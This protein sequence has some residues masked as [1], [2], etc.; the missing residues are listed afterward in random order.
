MTEEEVEELVLRDLLIYRNSQGGVTLSGGEPLTQP[1][2]AAAILARCTQAGVHTALDTSGVGEWERLAM[3]LPVTDLV[4]L[5][6][7]HVDTEKHRRATGVDCAGI[8]ANAARLLQT[9]ANLLVRVPVVPGFNDRREDMAAI[10]D[11]LHALVKTSARSTGGG[12]AHLA[13]ELLPFHKLAADKYKAL[14]MR[15]RAAHLSPPTKEEI[16]VLQEAFTS[17]GL[18]V[19]S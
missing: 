9:G 7:K 16:Q 14:G 12:G 18:R 8:L 5:D 1:E 15:Y 2:F 6:L 17:R 11:A 4:I 19:V 13:V 10:A 3:V